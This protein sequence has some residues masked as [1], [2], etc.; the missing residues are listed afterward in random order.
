MADTKADNETSIIH[1]RK[2]G[3][4]TRHERQQRERPSPF[5]WLTGCGST[6][7]IE[8]WVCTKCGHSKRMG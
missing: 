5:S 1:C 4:H 7:V 2:R 8:R 3:L 6:R